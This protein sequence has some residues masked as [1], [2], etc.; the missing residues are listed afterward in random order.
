MLQRLLILASLSLLLLAGWC[1][2]AQGQEDDAVESARESL[3]GK[4]NFP[5]Y[6]RQADSAR[7]IRLL[8]DADDTSGRKNPPRTTTPRPAPPPT[9]RQSSGIGGFLQVVGL[10][11]LVLLLVA[12]GALL[13]RALMRNEVTETASSK[14]VET[15]QD[16]DRVENLPFQLR[17]PTGDF[18]SEARRLYEAGQFSEAVLYY[19]SYQLMQLDRHQV[20]RLAKGKTNRQYLRET[21]QRPNIYGI[22]EQTMVAFEDVFFGHHTIPREQFEECWNRLSQ[23]QAELQHVERAAA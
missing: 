1:R 18:L 16:V 20:I 7:P 17:K 14:V 10:M 6:D 21:R 23:F 11:V 15:S 12:I 4:T 3:S 8:P 2:C 5:W 22:L 13:A 9:T 19:Y